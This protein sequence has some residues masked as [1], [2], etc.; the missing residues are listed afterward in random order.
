M[1]IYMNKCTVLHIFNFKI[2]PLGKEWF[3]CGGCRRGREDWKEGSRGRG[4]DGI[5]GGG[6]RMCEFGGEG[7]VT[8]GCCRVWLVWRIGG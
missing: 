6:K 8:R 1:Y 2:I 4:G 3:G 7:I 5:L